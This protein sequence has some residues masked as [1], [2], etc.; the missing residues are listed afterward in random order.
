MMATRI[1]D[2]MTKNPAILDV[3]AS[4]LQAAQAMKAGDIGDVV[5]CDHGKIWGIVTDRDLVVRAMAEGTSPEQ[6]R[7][8]DVC[9]HELTT[10]TPDASIDQALRLMREHAL[11]RLPVVKGDKP[12]GIVA[13]GDLAVERDPESALADISAARPNT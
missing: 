8:R 3:D 13:L 4:A 6:V 2:V 9:S 12:V 10:I 5:V 7:L 1:A 11:R